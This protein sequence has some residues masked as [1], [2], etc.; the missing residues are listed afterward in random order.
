MKIHY[1]LLLLII[2]VSS[3]ADSYRCVSPGG[4]VVHQFKPCA[5]AIKEPN[6]ESRT[7]HSTT[8]KP[9]SD[10][11]P[12]LPLRQTT[13]SRY[14]VPPEEIRKLRRE[15]KELVGPERAAAECA[16]ARVKENAIRKSDPLADPLTSLELFDALSKQDLFC[17]EFKDLLSPRR[18]PALFG[19]PPM[20]GAP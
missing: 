15:A 14:S 1:L 20:P 3:I 18:S 5:D 10:E 8:E 19:L 11:N 12:G 7:R 4:I 16:A 6:S 17:E 13:G 9:R 2:P